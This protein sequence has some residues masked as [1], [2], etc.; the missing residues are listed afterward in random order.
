[1]SRTLRLAV[2]L[3]IAPLALADDPDPKEIV[4]KVDKATKEVKAVQYKVQAWGEGPLAEDTPRVRGV[5][6][7]RDRNGQ[8]IPYLR[9]EAK[10]Q[11]PGDE[12]GREFLVVT[13]GPACAATRQDQ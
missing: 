8:E 7:A 12:E 13:D 2:C 1:M 5:V 9:V 11:M 6:S 10:V 3:L 4:A